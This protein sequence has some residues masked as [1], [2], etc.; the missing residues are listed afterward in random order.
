MYVDAAVGNKI[1]FSIDLE[2]KSTT[3][4]SLIWMWFYFPKTVRKIGSWYSNEKSRTFWWWDL[5]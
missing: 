1:Y 4:S 5:E 3:V 2:L